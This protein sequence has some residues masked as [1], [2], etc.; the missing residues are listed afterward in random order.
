MTK[1]KTN[2]IKLCALVFSVCL[3]FAVATIPSKVS[4]EETASFA[5]EQEASIRVAT[6][7]VAGGLRFT[8]NVNSA[9]LEN[10]KG[11]EITFGTLIFPAGNSVNNDLSVK[12]NVEALKAVDI[13]AR[14]EE[15][16]E[17]FTFHASLV[18]DD[19]E[20]SGIIENMG[21]TAD[22]DTLNKVKYNLFAMD[23]TA[24]AYAEVNGAVIYTAPYTTSML[25]TAAMKYEADNT[26]DVAKGYLGEVEIST[27][28]A[29]TVVAGEIVT[30]D[31]VVDYV[32]TSSTKLAIGNQTVSVTA[33]ENIN[34]APSQLGDNGGSVYVF[35]QGKTT[36]I[37]VVKKQE[38]LD[39]GVVDYSAHNGKIYVTLGTNLVEK[40]SFEGVDYKVGDTVGDE[41]ETFIK[42]QTDEG[43]DSFVGIRGKI[44]SSDTLPGVAYTVK[45]KGTANAEKTI[46]Y[47]DFYIETE[48]L[49]YK[50]NGIKYWTS[51]IETPDDLK[52]ALNRDYGYNSG[53][54]SR[55]SEKGVIYTVNSSRERGY[56]IGFY[57][58]HNNLDMLV[59]GAYVNWSFATTATQSETYNGGFA[60]YFDGFG[61]SIKNYKVENLY[62]LFGKL[63]STYSAPAQAD[64]VNGPMIKNFALIDV[65]TNTAYPALSY[66]P[67]KNEATATR[68]PT[69]SNVYVKYS[70][71]VEGVAGIIRNPSKNALKLNNVFVEY[72][73]SVGMYKVAGENKEINGYNLYNQDRMPEG[74][75]EEPY[76]LD[77]YPTS[78]QNHFG[79]VL[80]GALE[81]VTTTPSNITNVVV[82]SQ[83]PIAHFTRSDHPGYQIVYAKANATSVIIKENRYL[84]GG[85]TSETN[86]GYTFAHTFGYAS[87]E[88]KGRILTVIGVNPGITSDLA[89][90]KTLGTYSSQAGSYCP[91]CGLASL[92]DSKGKACTR[93]P[94]CTGIM[95][96]TSTW[97]Q[98]LW[99]SPAAYVWTVH[100][101]TNSADYKTIYSA[102]NGVI[103][104]S[105]VKKYNNEEHMKQDTANNS[106]SSFASSPYWSV[107]GGVIT[108]VGAQA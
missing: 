92:T 13:G 91:E 15:V 55:V 29:N 72:N 84:G 76:F 25:K 14:K 4:A 37:K 103:K 39:G 7:D 47:K 34:V 38:V 64:S 89:G 16:T 22:E 75:D 41:G 10:Y 40:V 32:A 79:G 54:S 20:I 9:W 77:L 30:V 108:W 11:S 42:T 5:I 23:F 102:G 100:D 24:V 51:V 3:T 87:N 43:V 104:F 101:L 45:V 94:E 28:T 6:G 71:D 49:I 62:G 65:I 50:V 61:Y 2:L 59:D 67:D 56:N 27:V 44:S 73:G 63:A 96:T 99:S 69:V 17:D 12:E 85:L 18:F 106:F 58:L 21:G 60:G 90:G 86:S 83:L 36:I 1:I 66:G 48:D 52:F 82:K 35:D 95:I 19:A 53:K 26:N 68:F 31:D 88:T 57:R 78:K 98:D 81:L 80:F 74:F 8:T 33:G 97:Y 93:T 105:G 70:D 107:D 46:S